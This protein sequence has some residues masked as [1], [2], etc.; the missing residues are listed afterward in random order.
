MSE[1]IP[2]PQST[3]KLFSLFTEAVI[4]SGIKE[5]ENM[6]AARLAKLTKDTPDSPSPEQQH[7]ERADHLA[8]I[9]DE[10][11]EEHAEKKP[12]VR[13]ACGTIDKVTDGFI[14]VVV[15]PSRTF[16]NLD[17]ITG[18]LESLD[19]VA[20]VAR[21]VSN[22]WILEVK[23]GLLLSDVRE[24]VKKPFSGKISVVVMF[25]ERSMAYTLWRIADKDVHNMLVPVFGG[26]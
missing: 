15:N 25:T 9:I 19:H 21:Y 13:G 12:T 23:D 16:D 24:A 8:H 1:A 20:S 18:M 10:D 14:V 7:I 22:S 6:L 5:R 11:L 26:V 2:M 17:S 4:R 3:A